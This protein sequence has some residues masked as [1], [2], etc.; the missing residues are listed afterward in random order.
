MLKITFNNIDFMF[1]RN[2][3]GTHNWCCY[4]YND[5]YDDE[6]REY[7]GNLQ[8]MEFIHYLLPNVDNNQQNILSKILD[9]VNDSY[10]E[11]VG[12]RFAYYYITYRESLSFS[13]GNKT[14]LYQLHKY[15]KEMLLRKRRGARS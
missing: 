14:R 13:I 7:L 5:C 3:Y 4:D 15:Y 6:P 1:D 12:G 11:S 2:A 10:I 8:V 9:L